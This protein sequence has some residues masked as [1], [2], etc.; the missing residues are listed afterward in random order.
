[1]SMLLSV[2]REITTGIRVSALL[3]ILCG[4]AYPLLFTVMGGIFFPS[5]ANGSLVKN[6]Q[7]Q[8]VGSSLIGQK[9]SSERY[10][11]GRVSSL[12]YKA[13]ASGSPNYGPTNKA[14]L[15]RIRADISRLEQA[16]GAKPT[17][18]LVTNSGSGLDPHITPAGARIQFA[19]VAR[20]RGATPEQV[21]SLV[22]QYT[23]GR[24]WGIFG[25][26]RVNVLLLNLALD[27]SFA[28]GK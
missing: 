7:G 22:E 9:F 3:L 5:Q 24:F 11:Q 25:E 27:Q 26:P 13:E 20:A 2:L 17:A 28:H 1:M 18:D 16:N 4:L 15:E 12:D 19:R 14:L 8:I 21:Q 10:F 23:E 6:A